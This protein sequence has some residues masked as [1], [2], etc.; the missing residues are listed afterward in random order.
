MKFALILFTIFLASCKL[1]YV[2]RADLIQNVSVNI[3]QNDES[4]F[5]IKRYL[6]GK[7]NPSQNKPFEYQLL[8]TRTQTV[9]GAG[10]GSDSFTASFKLTLTVNAVLKDA[11]TGKV[12]FSTTITETTNYIAEKDNQIKDFTSQ[13][14]ASKNISSTVAEKIYNTIQEHFAFLNDKPIN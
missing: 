8:L 12:L 9:D 14:Q 3:K 13:M 2:K 4:D 7:F 6:E 10:I 1:H 11:K 5:I